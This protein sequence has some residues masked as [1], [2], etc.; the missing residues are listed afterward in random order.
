MGQRSIRVMVDDLTGKDLADGDGQT[1]RFS[2]DGIRYEIDVDQR[3]ADKLRSTLAPYVRAGR[4][5]RPSPTLRRSPGTLRR[6]K[7]APDPA[8]VR[9]WAAAHGI[10]V[11]NRGRVPSS[12]IERFTAAGN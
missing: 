11:S 3:G 4:R 2:L 7:V 5:V 9:A 8:A 1:V 10:E 6:S 12:V